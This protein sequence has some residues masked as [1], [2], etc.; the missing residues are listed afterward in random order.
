[1]TAEERQEWL[2]EI[3]TT[4][5]ATRGMY[6]HKDLNRVEGV[7]KDIV[8]AVKSLGYKFPDLVT[9]T[10]WT[11][12]DRLKDTD[13]ARYLGNI[14]KLRELIPVFPTTPVAPGVGERLDYRRANDIEKILTDVSISVGNL[15][16][17]WYYAGETI[18][19][20]V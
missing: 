2:G 13:M 20:E 1:M 3:T 19:G 9:K 14:A 18:S 12:K 4:P 16:Q 8:G 11:Y 15:T 5:A 6:T 10:D 17:T 7:V